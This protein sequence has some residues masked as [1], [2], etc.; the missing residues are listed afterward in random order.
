MSPAP[1]PLS[2]VWF[3][4]D[5]RVQDHAALSAAAERGRVLPLYIWEDEQLTHPEFGGA[6]LELINDA[7]SEL[8]GRL[9]RLGAPLHVRRGEAAAVIAELHAEYGF[10]AVYAHQETGNW[11]SYQRDRRVRAWARAAGLPFHEPPQNGVVRRLKNRDSW[12]EEWEARMGAA[13]LL[14]PAQLCGPPAAPFAALTPQQAGVPPHDLTLP[15]PP[16]TFGEELAHA[17][18]ASFLEGRGVDYQDGIGSPLRAEH[19]CS[20]LSV[21]LMHGTLSL[22]TAVQA[23]RQR[24]AAVRGR[25]GRRPALGA[26][27]A[28]LREPP[29][30]A[31]PLHAAAGERT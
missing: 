31:L 22:R 9:S 11:V 20:R 26:L 21:H 24:L 28:G 29:A 25:P 8:S 17:T 10:G 27:A 6:Q 3:K 15:W 19:S 4:R 16:G 7:L 14:A 30:L 13:P 5:L 23:T 12:A 18:L 2:L 1:P